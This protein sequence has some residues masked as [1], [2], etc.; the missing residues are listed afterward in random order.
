[1]PDPTSFLQKHQHGIS[2][3]SS[4]SG[5]PLGFA[6]LLAVTLASVVMSV[7]AAPDR[8]NIVWLVTEDNSALWYRLYNEEHG[9]AMPN[10]E[11]LAESG[12][13][14][15]HAYSNAPVCSIARS[16]IISGVYA[17][18]CGVEFH[19]KVRPVKMPA[20]L[21]PFPAYLRKAGYHTS[22]R[23]KTDYNFDLSDR[24]KPWD[25]SSEKASF[26][27]RAPGQSFFHVRNFG[28]THE[29]Q[30]F[31]GLP[32]GK[33]LAA[34][35]AEVALFPYHPD[36][37]LMRRKYAEYLTRHQMAD[38]E[39]GAVISQLEQDGLLDDTFIFHY[40][41][42][43]GVLPRSKGHLYNDGL[44][45][46]MVVHVPKNWRH[47]APAEPG[48][49]IDGVVQFV[50]LSATVLNL[51]G[52]EIPARIDGRPFLGKGVGLEELNSRD[53]SLGYANRMDE[54]SDMV[55]SLQK[56]RYHYIRSYQPYM[57]E[58]Q[59]VS[60]RYKQAALEE[61]KEL[62][63]EGK[64]NEARSGFFKPRA[65]EMLF[66]TEADPHEINN[67]ANDPAFGDVLRAMRKGFQTR[68]K[69]LP[70][71]GFFPETYLVAEAGNDWYTYARK[72][73]ERIGE[74]MDIADLQ[75]GSAAEAEPAVK[76]ALESDDEVKRYWGLLVCSTLEIKSEGVIEMAKRLV[77]SDSSRLNRSKAAEYLGI[78]EAADPMP[79]LSELLNTST[80]DLE[81]ATILESVVT[82]QD[83]GRYA[84]DPASVRGAPWNKKKKGYPQDQLEYLLKQAKAE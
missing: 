2:S 45:V 76:K 48:T 38:A 47:L 66:D 27:N 21:Q 16:T 46:A 18:A 69:N 42:H 53:T 32:K 25:E 83:R 54:K 79:V 11:R 71:S 70:D 57:A 80:D 33:P 6:R 61:W 12:L 40:G 39:M 9:A 26:R 28:V 1:M 31:Q 59:Y 62:F 7:S 43:G 49:R 75:L 84:F 50:D 35:P 14:F 30:L 63:A 10:I 55:R 72:N 65:A 58:L 81:A 8:P 68:F 15:N 41:D 36:T 13:V 23:S 82:V 56:G 29:G 34:D 74:L 17:P 4:S 20:G 77:A 22:N 60:Y 78:I 19:R 3:S 24:E 73:Q 51:A 64:L 37:P 44:Q 5:R 67:L 52:I